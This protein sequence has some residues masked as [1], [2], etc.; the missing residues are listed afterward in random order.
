LQRRLQDAIL[1]SRREAAVSE[2]I[3]E[4]F[5]LSTTREMRYLSR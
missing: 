3:A 2:A 5:V 4:R 1:L